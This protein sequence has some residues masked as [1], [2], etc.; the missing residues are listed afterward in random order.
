MAK[1]ISKIQIVAF[2]TNE[3]GLVPNDFFTTYLENNNHKIGKK[4]D[5]AIGFTL[6]LPNETAPTKIVI[7]SIL[8]LQQ[9]Y[10]GIKDVN[11]YILFVDLE[12]EESKEKLKEI[13]DYAE[14]YCEMGKKLYVLGILKDETDDKK[15]RKIKKKDVINPLDDMED[16]DY[17]Y[18]EFNLNNTKEMNDIIKEIFAFCSKE[19][20]KEK[21]MKDKV[22]NDGG[23]CILF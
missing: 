1:E 4:V 2:S 5:G 14:K 8:N 11:C 16:L 19:S 3:E 21:I 6:T 22:K 12:I 10:L 17:E 18:K 9:E 13:L 23:S 15:A 7:C 20:F